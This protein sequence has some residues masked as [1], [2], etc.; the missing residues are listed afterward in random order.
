MGFLLL[1]AETAAA[2]EG[3]PPW[4]KYILG[5]LGTLVLLGVYAWHT[6]KKRIPTVIVQ[7]KEAQAALTILRDSHKL[8][9]EALRTKCDEDEDKLRKEIQ[10]WRDKHTKERSTR[11]WWQSKAE[12]FAKQLGEDSGIPPDIDKTHYQDDD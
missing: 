1:L 10:K 4:A 12:G 7:I 11:A 8:E 3:L 2:T 6:E 5:P 9:M